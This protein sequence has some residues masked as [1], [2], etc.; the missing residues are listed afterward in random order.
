M[1]KIFSANL[2]RSIGLIRENRVAE[3]AV[4]TG[5]KL[6]DMIEILHGVKPGD[7]VVLKPIEKMKDGAR[8]KIAEK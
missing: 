8:I 5:E 6:G 3:S 4:T 7:T 1:K 2:T